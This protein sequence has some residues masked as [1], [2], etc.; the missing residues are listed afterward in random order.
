[1]ASDGEATPTPFLHATAQRGLVSG[2]KTAQMLVWLHSLAGIRR[3]HNHPNTNN[4][5][6]AYSRL[7]G[8][9]VAALQ[10]AIFLLLLFASEAGKQQQ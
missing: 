3:L 6:L 9:E 10:R 1:M 7:G 2:T 4:V 5:L 8:F